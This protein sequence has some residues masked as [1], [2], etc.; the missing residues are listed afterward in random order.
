MLALGPPVV[1]L[2]ITCV[3]LVTFS[4]G[5]DAAPC[6]VTVPESV[7]VHAVARSAIANNDNVLIINDW[8]TGGKLMPVL[9]FSSEIP[10]LN[11]SF[12]TGKLG[13]AHSEQDPHPISPD[14]PAPRRP[15]GA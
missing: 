7:L 2:G 5:T 11:L 10:R 6:S 14:R 1:V 12:G 15:A 4:P 9:R 3:S 13:G 8:I